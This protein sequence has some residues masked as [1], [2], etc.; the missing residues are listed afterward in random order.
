MAVPLGDVV[1]YIYIY[2]YIFPRI[3]E[4]CYYFSSISCLI[5]NC[6]LDMRY[7]SMSVMVRMIK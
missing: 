2:I 7:F 4:G 6:C 3:V 1:I 5:K